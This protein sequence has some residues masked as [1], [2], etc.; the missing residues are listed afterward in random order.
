MPF[1]IS[2]VY[3]VNCRKMRFDEEHKRAMALLGFT[4]FDSLDAR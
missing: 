3:I 1:R 2:I 4:S